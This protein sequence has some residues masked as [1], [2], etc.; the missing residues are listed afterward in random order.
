VS[1]SATPSFDA[2][3]A[4]TFKITLSGN[5]TSST[6]S[7]VVAGQALNFVICQDATGGRTFAW[8]S[9]V[10]GG[11]AVGQGAG[12]CSAQSFVYDGSNAYATASG[13]V[14]Q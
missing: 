5:V 11:V 14:E 13:V 3:T 9:N 12:K 10:K 4:S 7:N 1:Y 8:P 2:G 6:L